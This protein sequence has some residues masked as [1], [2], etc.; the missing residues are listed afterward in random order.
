[1]SISYLPGSFFPQRL[2]TSVGH[3]RLG[4]R[5]LGSI[6]WDLIVLRFW[7]SSNLCLPSSAVCHPLFCISKT[8]A[9][10][11]IL[12]V[13]VLHIFLLMTQQVGHRITRNMGFPACWKSIIFLHIFFLNQLGNDESRPHLLLMSK[14]YMKGYFF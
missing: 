7:S 10:E 6:S 11:P 1:M 13:N 9:H 5:E 8:K 14:S 2:R 3:H 4:F 12:F